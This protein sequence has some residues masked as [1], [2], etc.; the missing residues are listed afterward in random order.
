MRFSQS[1]LDKADSCLL[2][3]QYAIEDPTYRGGSMRAVGTG[4]HGGLELLYNMRRD[5]F[6][7][8]SLEQCIE[9]GCA[10]FDVELERS[11]EN[12]IW[13]PRA[14][15][16]EAA[17]ALIDRMLTT[18]WETENGL[19]PL[20][21]RVVAVEVPWE[22]EWRGVTI[23]SR[24]I[25]LVLQDPNLWIWGVDH[26]TANKAW[27]KTK[28]EPRKKAQAPLY[29]WALE[30]LF[31]DAPGYAFAY[32]IMT[33][34]GPRSEPK[35]ERR[36]ATPTALQIQAALDRVEQASWLYDTFRV[37]ERDLPANPSSNLCSSTYC[38]FWNVCPYG[39]ALSAT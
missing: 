31:P 12:F 38:D 16:R 5:G 19:W 29:V 6:F 8:I 11:G 17:H 37:L 22:F 9:A 27:P 36:I 20:D 7:A 14:A 23:T 26:K 30:R 18:L 1:L 34:G 25:D 10:V 24:G 2:S 28:H 32:D 4:Y 39:A 13:D 33:Y 21:W 15:D 3:M 35:F